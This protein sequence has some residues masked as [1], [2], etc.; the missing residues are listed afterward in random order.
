MHEK[1]DEIGKLFAAVGLI[2]VGAICFILSFIN[3]LL[4]SLAIIAIGAAL[5]G[6][7]GVL[8]YVR[9]I[10]ITSQSR[11]KKVKTTR[12]VRDVPLP[13]PKPVI[14]ES[15]EEEKPKEP[16]ILCDTCQYYNQYNTRQKCKYLTDTDRM[17]MINAGIECVEYKIK[18]SLLDEE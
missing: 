12:V 18:L 15:I 10:S 17:K 2:A 7:G 3:G 8:Y 5:C 9:H 6:F 4:N 16:E 13:K 11:V 14:E 1:M